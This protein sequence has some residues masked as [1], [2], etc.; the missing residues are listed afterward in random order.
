MT[1]LVSNSFNLCR[2]LCF[3]SS[4]PPSPLS[5]LFPQMH[6]ICI[7]LTPV[8]S[9]LFSEGAAPPGPAKAR[10]SHFTRN[11]FTSRTH[12]VWIWDWVQC[13]DLPI[14]AGF[15]D[16][17]SKNIAR[18]P[19]PMPDSC[20]EAG[21]QPKKIYLLES[22]NYDFAQICPSK[23][24]LRPICQEPILQMYTWHLTYKLEVFAKIP[25]TTEILISLWEMQPILD[26]TLKTVRKRQTHK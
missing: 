17:N 26:N 15:L 16:R 8:C 24:G 20:P 6:L 7:S 5:C 14:G 10:M 13:P 19:H 1:R 4:P 12:L 22:P 2:F 3:L 11:A 23:L 21:T 18:V 25:E 9:S